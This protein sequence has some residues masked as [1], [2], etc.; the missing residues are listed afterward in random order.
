MYSE[1][2]YLSLSGIQHYRFCTRQCSFIHTEKMWTENF[3]T[4]HG[5]ALHEKVHNES[6]ESRGT[7]RIERGLDIASATLGLVGQTDAVEFYEDGTVCPVEY[8]RGTV[9]EDITDEVQLC[10]QAI[11]LEEMLHVSIEYGYLFYEKIR[12]RQKVSFTLELREQTQKLSDEYHALISSGEIPTA[13]Y[14]KKCE[15]CS[16]IDSCFPETAGRNKSVDGYIKRRL[17]VELEAEEG[18]D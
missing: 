3:F 7:K 6:G 9:K 4:A 12:R 1:D 2:D 17:A 11:C 18:D 16:F 8:K 14:S 13:I 15:S 5:R 10:A